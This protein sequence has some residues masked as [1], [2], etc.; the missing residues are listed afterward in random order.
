[1]GSGS[2]GCSVYSILV[3]VTKT[4]IGL[5]CESSLDTKSYVHELRTM[6]FLC[7]CVHIVVCIIDHRNMTAATEKITNYYGC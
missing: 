2:K 5:P 3:H 4:Q 1:M 6:E 7:F